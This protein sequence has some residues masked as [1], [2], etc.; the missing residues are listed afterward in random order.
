MLRV[1]VGRSAFGPI[2][3]QTPSDS[4]EYPLADFFGPGDEGFIL[5]GARGEFW[6]TSAG[7]TPCSA[8][9]SDPVGKVEDVSGLDTAITQATSAARP[10]HYSTGGIKSA[11]GGSVAGTELYLEF[12]QFTDLSEFCIWIVYKRFS[13]SDNFGRLLRIDVNNY[14]NVRIDNDL[15]EFTA[16][17]VG[18]GAAVDGPPGVVEMFKTGTGANQVAGTSY[19]T[20]NFNGENAPSLTSATTTPADSISRILGVEGANSAPTEEFF[21]LVRNRTADADEKALVRNYITETFGG[22]S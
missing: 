11:K 4:G 8:S 6:T 20:I 2:A 9:G 5:D 22:L 3:V 19:P 21:V 10:I 18:T 14:I 1:G 15:V 7:A 12:P 13:S 16:S 17:G